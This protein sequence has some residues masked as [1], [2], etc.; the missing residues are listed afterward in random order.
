MGHK[1]VF[2]FSHLSFWLRPALLIW[3]NLHHVKSCSCKD[4]KVVSMNGYL[5][6]FGYY[7][8]LFFIYSLLEIYIFWLASILVQSKWTAMAE[9][10]VRVIF[11]K[12]EASDSCG[13]DSGS[14]ATL[15]GPASNWQSTLSVH[16][17]PQPWALVLFNTFLCLLSKKH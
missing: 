16:V 7:F 15:F 10:E 1:L 4:A 12:C 13:V 6:Y 5:A 17:H 9:M 11:V 14:R 8:C 2:D 3:K